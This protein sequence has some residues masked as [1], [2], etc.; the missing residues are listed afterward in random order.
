MILVEIDAARPSYCPRRPTM[1]PAWQLPA[2]AGV[3]EG[4]QGQ[5]S[6]GRGRMDAFRALIYFLRES[7]LFNYIT[8]NKKFQ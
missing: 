4:Q 3:C 6:A 2:S 8:R 7:S 5:R 1:A